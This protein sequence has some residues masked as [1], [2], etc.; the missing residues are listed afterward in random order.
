[1]Q[2]EPN[3]ENLIKNHASAPAYISHF[4]YFSNHP[5]LEGSL[6]PKENTPKYDLHLLTT[7]AALV[8]S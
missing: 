2:R 5:I 6:S 7:T 1:M 3:H 4:P 8:A